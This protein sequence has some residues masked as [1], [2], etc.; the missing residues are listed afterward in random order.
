VRIC[1]VSHSAAGLLEQPTGGAERQAALLARHLATRS[2]DVAF[3]VPGYKGRE[4]VVHGVRLVPGWPCSDVAIA[5]RAV[6]RLRQLR[7]A[8]IATRADVVYTRGITQFAPAAL[9]IARG[10][11]LYSLFGLASDANLSGV[12]ARYVFGTS[13]LGD[14]SSRVVSR[15]FTSLTL[16]TAH[17]VVAQTSAQASWCAARGLSH[18]VIPNIV[19]AVHDGG[20]VEAEDIDVAWVSNVQ[21]EERR[22]K[23]LPALLALAGTLPGLRFVVVGKLSAA[24]AQPSVSGLARLPNVTLAGQVSQQETLEWLRRSKIILNTSW[25]EGFSNV[26]LEGWAAGKPVA[27]LHVDPDGYLS[28]GLLGFFAGGSVPRLR[29]ELLALASDEQKRREIGSRC[30]AHIL[31]HNSPDV[32]CARYERLIAGRTGR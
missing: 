15:P 1:I 19:E 17:C 4:Q 9:A 20:P 29:E 11:G 24:H 12:S 26:M 25:Y 7:S 6:Q 27:S 3:L 18:E 8:I 10:A 13:P 23:G 28:S 22:R 14:L 16:R 2:H 30:R 32:V 5:G 21:D 31:A